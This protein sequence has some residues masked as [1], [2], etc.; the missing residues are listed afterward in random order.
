MKMNADRLSQRIVSA[1]ILILLWT[2]SACAPI[3]VP[4]LFRPPS[5]SAIPT[6]PPSTPIAGA[7]TPIFFATQTFSA[8]F[9]TSTPEP[10]ANDLTFISDISYPD[11]TVV[12]PNQTIDKQWLVQN[13]GTC[14]WDSTYRLLLVGGEAQGAQT[15]SPLFPARAG[16]QAALRVIFTARIIAGQYQSAWQAY[17]PDGSAFGDTIYVIIIVQ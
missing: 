8:P 12:F 16:A 4:T 6:T 10:C 1:F 3:A 11:N 13:T 9:D 17:A 5:D 15:E 7:P 2:L 14:N